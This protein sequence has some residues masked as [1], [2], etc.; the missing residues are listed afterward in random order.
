MKTLL[1]KIIIKIF[2]RLFSTHIDRD[3]F[4]LL[5]HVPLEPGGLNSYLKFAEEQ[6]AAYRAM[7]SKFPD[8]NVDLYMNDAAHLFN[9]VKVL[10]Y[11][12]I[13]TDELRQLLSA[14]REVQGRPNALEEFKDLA[15]GYAL[16]YSQE[17]EDVLLARFFDNKREGFYVDVG[18]HHP[19]RF[20]NTYYLYK[21]GW[22]GI[23]IEPNQSVGDLFNELRPRDIN[24]PFAVAAADEEKDLYLFAESALNTFSQQLADEYQKNG[25]SLIETRKVR[26]RRLDQL[27][28]EHIKNQTIDFMSIDVEDYELPVLESNDWSK[29][30]PSLLLIE[31]LN[32][33]MNH[34]DHFP[35]HAFIVRQG[36]ELCAKTYNTV[37]YKDIRNK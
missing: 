27:L 18:A 35:V 17:G 6:H 26:T 32:F 25:H 37:F 13:E 5:R 33:D 4:A 1:I 14:F 2:N 10:M 23:N 16:Y 21:L 30:R 29:Y 7:K 22:K 24:I 15:A 11:N 20:S 12:H 28:D 34:I 31:I 19:K 3:T 8:S 9:N 36:Y